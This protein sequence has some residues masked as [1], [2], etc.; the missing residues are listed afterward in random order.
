[1]TLQYNVATLCRKPFLPDCQAQEITNPPNRCKPVTKD[2]DA[3]QLCYKNIYG[4]ATPESL[5]LPSDFFHVSGE[6]SR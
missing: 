6:R 4:I 1:M 5:I 2:V 3:V